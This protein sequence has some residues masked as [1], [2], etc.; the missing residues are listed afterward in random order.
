MKIEELKNLYQLF[1]FEE[2]Y[3]PETE[4]YAVFGY[5]F[6]F[7]HN[8]EFIKLKTD[9]K[10]ENDIQ[11]MKKEYERMGYNSAVVHFY[12]NLEEAEETLFRAFFYPDEN[13]KY[14]KQEY[15]RFCQRQ[16]EKLQGEFK[17]IEGA[18]QDITSCIKENLVE[19]I[20]KTRN[21]SAPRL[22]IMEAAA[23][24]GKTCTVYEILNRLVDQERLQIP[25]FVELSKNRNARLFR[26]VLQDEIDKK[27][28][29]LSS[30]VV[31]YE[32][33]KGNIPLIIDGFDELIEQSGNHL[34]DSDERSLSML[35][36][37]AELLGDDSNAWVLLTT[38]NS[39]IFSGD[40]FDEWVMSK[41]GKGCIVDRVRILR[42][43]VQE[44]LGEEKY[45]IIQ[46]KK[47]NI[48]EMANPVLLT[49]LRNMTISEL[50]ANIDSQDSVLNQYL[51][52]LLNRD[53]ERLNLLLEKEEQ[54]TVLE[55]LAGNFIQYDIISETNEF[56]QD[57]LRE[58]LEDRFPELLERYKQSEMGE[59]I[60]QTAQEYV[61][62]LS[63]SCLLDRLSISDNQYGF[64][65]EFVLGIIA[66][67]AVRDGY[68]E[69]EEISERY[70]D[71]IATAY[72]GRNKEVRLQ[73]YG[74]IVPV[75]ERVDSLSKLTIECALLHNVQSSYQ[76]QY[77]QSFVFSE[78]V[79]FGVESSFDNCI[80]DNC[81]F[82]KCD[83]YAPV[84]RKC[85]FFNCQFYNL[86]VE[87]KADEELVFINC[88]GDDILQA[89][90]KEKVEEEEN[91]D[92]YEKIVLEQFW[93]P[94][95]SSAELRR[96]YTALFKGVN[97]REHENIEKAI[98][99]LLRKGLI[100]E[101]N[102]CYELNTTSIV[103]IKRILGR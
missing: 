75:L 41:L 29:H 36:T 92:N 39:A 33:K 87:G 54:Y 77:I 51:S 60:I 50:N 79:K 69:A 22:T 103:E 31:I 6:G 76:D 18:F 11:E 8:I 93:K 48:Q 47:I 7:F 53:C 19:Y 12:H 68:L 35:S 32:I 70:F 78:Y 94:G 91:V 63:H 3:I 90:Y 20:I 21:I 80:F 4:S 1:G 55:K 23:G 14:L 15:N 44:W 17:Y 99:S 101:L 16:S 49:F 57:L 5:H 83:I 85:K 59:T 98:R 88:T 25:L 89:K 96:T 52:L 64:V 71:I 82:R 42:P 95:Y 73:L 100:R 37:I 56:I 66:G 38:R 58:I 43:S 28:T 72:E 34:E 26:Y 86:S 81:L 65:N 84:F 9:K 30:N 2:E 97:P 24:Y 62:R 27:F 61:Q 102:I 13:K 45:N 46:A 10:I 67:D 74:K 40:L